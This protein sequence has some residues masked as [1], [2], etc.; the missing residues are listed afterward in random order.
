MLFLTL[1]NTNIWFPQTSGPL[2]SN[3][4]RHRHRMVVMLELGTR[5]N[6]CT[7]VVCVG[8]RFDTA[9]VVPWVGLVT[10]SKTPETESHTV[11]RVYKI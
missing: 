7:S 10:V 4:N 3:E 6:G 5:G 9:I 2:G 8:L 11:H 1:H